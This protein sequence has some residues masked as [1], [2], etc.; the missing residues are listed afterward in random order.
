MVSISW[1]N[2]DKI[3]HKYWLCVVDDIVVLSWHACRGCRPT[4]VER[5]RIMSCVQFSPT[6]NSS[7]LYWCVTARNVQ[8]KKVKSR[9]MLGLTNVCSTV[10]KNSFEICGVVRTLQRKVYPRVSYRKLVTFARSHMNKSP[11]SSFELFRSRQKQSQI[12]CF[13]SAVIKYY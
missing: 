4:S 8:S 5:R 10:L 3:D 9:L 6:C 7:V 12:A 13:S 2:N 1:N 11:F